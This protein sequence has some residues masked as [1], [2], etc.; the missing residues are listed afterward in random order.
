MPG[1]YSRR[2]F[3]PNRDAVGVYEQQGRVRLDANLNELVDLLDRR[4]RATSL[5]TLGPAVV[6]KDTPDG[7]RIVM[8]GPGVSPRIG[9]GRAYVDGILVDNHGRGRSGLVQPAFDP[10]LEEVRGMGS[11]DL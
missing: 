11:I 9:P 3:D 7:F 1:D 5:D 6:P 8:G 2:T 10:R 4:L